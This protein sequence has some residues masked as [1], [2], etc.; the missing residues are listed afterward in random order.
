MHLTSHAHIIRRERRPMRRATTSDRT[1]V[2]LT[3]QRRGLA[4]LFVVLATL[5][6]PALPSHA[7]PASRP[8]RLPDR[9]VVSR[10]AGVLPEGIG[11]GR[12]GTF[13][14]TSS[15][16]GAVYQGRLDRPQM[17]VFARAG[18]AGRT[19]AL[20]VHTDRVGRV[21]VAGSTALD[22]YSPSGRL[23]THRPAPAGQVGPASLN[24][25]VVTDDAVYVTDFAN[26]VIL[27]AP[28]L[29]SRVGVLQPWLDLTPVEPGLPPPY[30]FLNG[31]VA[32]ADQATLLVSSQGLEALLRVDVSHRRASVVDLGPGSFAADGLELHNR[33]LYAVVNYDPPAGQGVYIAQ[34]DAGLRRGRVV[35]AVTDQ[36][37]PFD[38]PTTLARDRWGRILV[39]NSQ[40][41]HPPGSSPYT[42]TAVR[43]P[44]TN[45]LTGSAAVGAQEGRVGSGRHP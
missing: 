39:V 16:T 40:L 27:R 26:P 3:R 13:F 29:G 33:T 22:V 43:E 44:A 32:S 24:D 36:F 14:V 34:L 20:G 35:A 1:K 42:V 30:W 6:V 2:T 21:F 7:A 4:A 25:L 23:L 10:D 5:A 38:S 28:L 19:S 41:D 12:Q 31:I 8:D 17:S 45:G 15:A 18:A 9:Y 37:A 11:L